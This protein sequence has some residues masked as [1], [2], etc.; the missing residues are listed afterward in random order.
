MCH[1]C[2]EAKAVYAGSLELLNNLES[3]AQTATGMS[4][5]VLSDW[6]AGV[7]LGI[8]AD[9]HL[10]PEDASLGQ[11]IEDLRRVSRRLARIT[12]LVIAAHGYPQ[13]SRAPSAPRT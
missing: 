3:H 13:G 8:G 1:L 12:S 7:P 6:L 9:S 5:A 2:Q 10:Q 4:G 11:A